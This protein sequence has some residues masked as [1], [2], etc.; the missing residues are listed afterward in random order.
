VT[1]GLL[2]AL[3]DSG[4]QLGIALMR[5]ARGKF[6]QH[7][8]A[9]AVDPCSRCL[10]EKVAEL[11][12]KPPAAAAVDPAEFVA[13]AAHFLLNTVCDEHSRL[14]NLELLELL[15]ALEAVGRMA[16]R[17]VAAKDPQAVGDR[18]MHACSQQAPI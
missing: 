4:W 7:D 8:E 3:E 2:P 10:L 15:T 14:R 13:D 12:R 16:L 1:E 5:F 18:I 11:A 9:W 17:G 6:D